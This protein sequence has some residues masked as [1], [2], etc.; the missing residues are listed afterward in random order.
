MAFIFRRSIFRLP[1]F[2]YQILCNFLYNIIHRSFHFIFDR[3][4]FLFY[5]NF[6]NNSV[7]LI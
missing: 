3:K 6:I 2:L 7:K 5:N 4:H 1:D